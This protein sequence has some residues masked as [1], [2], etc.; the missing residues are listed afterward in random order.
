MFF[1]SHS[2]FKIYCVF[3]TYGMSSLRLTTGMELTVIPFN[4]TGQRIRYRGKF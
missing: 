3:Y 4:S 1:F 2:V